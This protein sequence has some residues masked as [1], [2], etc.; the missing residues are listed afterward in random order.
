MPLWSA[1]S[2]LLPQLRPCVLQ[3]GK[4]RDYYLGHVEALTPKENKK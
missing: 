1:F 3:L 4:N 2:D